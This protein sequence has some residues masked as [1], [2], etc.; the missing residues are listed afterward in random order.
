MSPITANAVGKPKRTMF[1]RTAVRSISISVCS[2]S[3]ELLDVLEIVG[4]YCSTDL[5]LAVS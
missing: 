4:D 3:D 1:L 5:S 2:M